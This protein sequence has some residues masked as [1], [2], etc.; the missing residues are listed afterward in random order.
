MIEMT[1]L[2]FWMLMLAAFCAG[3][4]IALLVHNGSVK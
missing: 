2:Q 4:C 1:T 3:G